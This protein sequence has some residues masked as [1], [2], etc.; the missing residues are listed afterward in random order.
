[1][2]LSLSGRAHTSAATYPPL[3]PLS[4]S[5][6]QRPV[7]PAGAPGRATGWS[8]QPSGPHAED[9]CARVGCWIRPR[10][11]A[12]TLLPHTA[13]IR[14]RNKWRPR[15]P[16][17]Q[18]G[19]RPG[20]LGAIHPGLPVASLQKSARQANHGR[21]ATNPIGVFHFPPS[22]LAPGWKKEGACRRR[23][24][25][26][27]KEGA[28][29]RTGAE[30]EDHRRGQLHRRDAVNTPRTTPSTAA[31][32]EKRRSSA[33]GEGAGPERG[34]LHRRERL[35]RHACWGVTRKV[36]M[37]AQTQVRVLCTCK[38]KG[39]AQRDCDSLCK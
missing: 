10:G 25:A 29:S 36:R 20:A 12:M 30:G 8:R 17:A 14:G 32:G 4:S 21:Q 13:R 2:L 35:L 15:D 24:A 37:T 31:R 18:P 3:H 34:Q 19:E 26:S 38:F 23:R 27:G 39:R 11:W 7:N 5:L 16:P 9:R 33:S 22:L 6:F 28:G 1:L